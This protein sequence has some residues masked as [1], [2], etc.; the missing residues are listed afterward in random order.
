MP[1]PAIGAS[2][3]VS[4]NR[5]G[6]LDGESGFRLVRC[7]NRGLD[8][9]AV[10]VYCPGRDGGRIGPGALLMAL[11]RAIRRWMLVGVAVPVVATVA[12][13]LGRRLE[14]NHG[15]SLSSRGL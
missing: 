10:V 2:V 3:A 15:R 1:E 9:V 7:G 12:D 6:Q 4:P 13:R 5:Q 8:G 11:R 14:A